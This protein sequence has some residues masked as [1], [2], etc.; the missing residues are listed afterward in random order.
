MRD[1]L[2]T[3]QTPYEIL[4]IDRGAAK[5][6][7]DRALMAALQR[8]VPAN[9]A[10]NARDALVLHPA[11]RAWHDLREYDDQVL[12]GLNPQV[13]GQPARLLDSAERAITAKTWEDILKRK[14]PDLGIVH[15]LAVLW[16][17]WTI[18]AEEQFAADLEASG[19][20]SPPPGGITQ[21]GTPGTMPP[22]QE[23]W[24]KTIAY[25][26]MLTATPSF[27]N[28]RFGLQ[29]SESKVLRRQMVDFL[30]RTLQD[31]ALRYSMLTESQST[32]GWDALAEQ[33]RNLDLALTTEMTGAETLREAGIR[34][35]DGQT[36]ACGPLM[37]H[38]MGLLENIRTQVDATLKV[39]ETQRLKR[40]RQML[41]PY[42]SIAVLLSQHKTEAALAAIEQLPAKERQSAEVQALRAKAL[43]VQ[44]KHQA[45]IGQLEKAMETWRAA[46]QAG[47]PVALQQEIQDEIVS[48]VHQKALAI[49]DTQRDQA[50]AL[51]EQGLS[52][53]PDEKIRLTLAEILKRRGIDT[54]IRA[55]KEAEGPQ[56]MTR[57]ILGDLE[58]AVQD[59]E[60]AGTLGSADA[61]QQAEVA[62]SILKQA[63]DAFLDLPDELKA[64]LQEGMEAAQTKDW[65]KAIQCLQEVVNSLG[66][67]APETLR[68]SLATFYNN[69]GVEKFNQAGKILEE[70]QGKRLARAVQR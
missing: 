38:Y 15:G 57:Q 20:S 42:S 34:T 58:R 68:K 49:K 60:R 69:R 7:I 62:R 1:P 43:N 25:W 13:L 29:E 11:K 67:E 70:T 59:L 23:I 56:G 52:L 6:Q 51:L 28:G 48:A 3:E 9:I 47:G 21:A 35:K 66:Q 50:I 26:A 41:S 18:S 19:K 16:Y 33:Y 24:E 5:D 2:Q 61:A 37:L 8:R 55:Q 22:L 36:V 4:G 31:L 14:F 12:K 63:K 17:W 40:L 54:F 44:G 10:K 53:V 39:R 30:H 45:G 32:T 65:D 27:W 64:R 46:L